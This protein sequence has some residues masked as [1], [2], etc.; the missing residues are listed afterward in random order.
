MNDTQQ[1]TFNYND[2][3]PAAQIAARTAAERIKMRLRRTAEDIVEIGRE[4][5]EIKFQIGHGKFL[6]WIEAEFNMNRST[7][8]RFMAVA[9][10][11]GEMSQI[12][13]FNPSILYQLAAPSTPDEVIE[14]AT[15]KAAAGE[16]VS[17]E[18]VKR[19][20]AEAERAHAQAK[21]LQVCAMQNQQK[22]E[23]LRESLE[24]AQAKID[25]LSQREPQTKIQFLTKE[26]FPADYEA[27]KER[28]KELEEQLDEITQ[29]SI[30]RHKEAE[31]A[32]QKLADLKRN[33]GQEINKGVQERIKFHEKDLAE[34]ERKRDQAETRLDE[35]TQHIKLL[36]VKAEAHKFHDSI[37]GQW[38][39]DLIELSLIVTEFEYI[40]QTHDK[41][42]RL[43]KNFR[44][45]GTAIEMII[46]EKSGR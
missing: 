24:S 40:E 43:A 20:K 30:A 39:H 37:I 16:K 23:S 38:E 13:T 7:A 46:A 19:W 41:W 2:L 4:L 27:A 36:G 22:A 26:I 15:E 14:K 3:P 21:E 45:A 1:L 5:N 25:E 35:L 29:E 10:K 9:D 33:Q 28:A 12:A 42:L 18:D 6:P 8:H 17:V 11:F 32:R 34:I 44:D 31:D